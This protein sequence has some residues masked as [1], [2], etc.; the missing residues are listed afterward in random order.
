MNILFLGTA[1]VAGIVSF[2]FAVRVADHSGFFGVFGRLNRCRL[3]EQAPRYFCKFDFLCA[4]FLTGVR[5]FGNFA[6]NRALA[7]G[8]EVQVW[9]SRIGG[10]VI[11]FFGL[12]LVG[13]IKVPLPMSTIHLRLKRNSARAML[14]R[15]SFWHCVCGRLD[16]LCRRGLG[17]YFGACRLSTSLGILFVVQLCARARAPVFNSWIVYCASNRVYCQR[18]QRIQ[19]RKYGVWYNFSAAR[20]SR[21]YQ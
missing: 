13:L 7:V 2:F 5:P 21:F 6:S 1:F 19:I 10:V 16:A 17:Q 11:I 9:L 18:L 14:R 20:H 12:Y 8:P 3:S 4:Q 15:S